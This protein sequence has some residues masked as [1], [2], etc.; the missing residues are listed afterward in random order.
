MKSECV[1]TPPQPPNNNFMEKIKTFLK[2][3]T[4]EP[5]MLLDGMAFSITSVFIEDMQMRRI[6]EV[7]LGQNFF[8]CS[9]LSNYKNISE[10]V[11]ENFSVFTFYDGIIKSAIPLFFILF[12]GAWS[13]K[14]GRKAPLCTAQFGRAFNVLGLLLF[15]LVTSWPVEFMLIPTFL[16]SLGGGNV[17]FL[18]AANAYISDITSE[19][20]RTSRVGIAN[21]IFFLGGPIG[22]FTG[23]FIYDYG[24]YTAIFATA[25][26]MNIINLIYVV[27]FIEESHGPYAS[28]INT[29]N[30]PNKQTINLRESLAHL[31]GFEHKKQQNHIE[32]KK[33]ITAFK[34]IKDFFNPQRII[35]SFKCTLKKRE[36][37]T[38]SLIMLVIFC[39]LLRRLTRCKYL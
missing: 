31:Y 32:N 8:T 21:S 13:D 7:G 15:S 29:K 28:Q 36:G 2:N 23:K 17:C 35:E 33:D 1:K 12:M 26:T 39:S 19:S 4:V 10:K 14:Y 30:N 5:L 11:Q 3:V 37:N 22:T 34:M 9:N 27:F 20:S 16:E 25:L 6:C 38:K 18:T 24:G